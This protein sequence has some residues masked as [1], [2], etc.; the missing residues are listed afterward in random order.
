MPQSM[1]PLSLKRVVNEVADMVRRTHRG[2]FTVDTVL[3]KDD[4]QIHGDERL[5]FQALLNLCLNGID[6][7]SDGNTLVVTMC[8]ATR[9]VNEDVQDGIEVKVKDSGVGMSAEQQSRMFE[10]FFTTKPVGKGTGLGLA[11]VYGT[12]DEHGGQIE[13]SS[14]LNEGTTVTLWFPLRQGVGVD[15]LRDL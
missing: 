10:P 8:P 7:M 4:A 11:M 15:K 9:T 5:L 6:A 1:N 3:M 2:R 12:V 14:A 13:V